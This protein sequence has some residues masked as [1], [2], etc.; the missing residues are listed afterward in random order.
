MSTKPPP[1]TASFPPDSLESIAYA[2]AA[3]IPAREP[4]DKSRLGY[5][6]WAWLKERKGT[7]EEA[8]MNSGVRTDLPV[9]EVS[10]RIREQLKKSGVSL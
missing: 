1:P 4:N 9:P 6:V 3:G 2:A 8:V 5:S 7:L 10:A